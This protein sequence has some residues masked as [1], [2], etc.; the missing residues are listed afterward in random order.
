MQDQNRTWNVRGSG[1]KKR[2]LER[3][4][5]HKLNVRIRK[6]TLQN[7]FEHLSVAGTNL[8]LDWVHTSL[9][10]Y[11]W[12]VSRLRKL[13][14]PLLSPLHTISK[15]GEKSRFSDDNFLYNIAP[16]K[17]SICRSPNFL[18]MGFTFLMDANTS[19]YFYNYFMGMKQTLISHWKIKKISGIETLVLPFPDT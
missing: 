6:C 2:R 13:K 19:K 16:T 12:R 15:I 8:L 5:A 14:Y 1:R 11:T 18:R 10:G 7:P 17:M 3:R 9:G 4:L